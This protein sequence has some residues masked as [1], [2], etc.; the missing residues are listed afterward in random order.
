[1]PWP[2]GQGRWPLGPRTHRRHRLPIKPRDFSDACQ[3]VAASDPR[4]VYQTFTTGLDG[5]PMPSFAD[6]L[7]ED[8]RWQLVWYVMSL[9]HDFDLDRRAP[10]CSA[11]AR[12]QAA[13]SAASR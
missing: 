2:I 6:F 13:V 4:G 8:E 11:Q 1:M 9:R 12:G 3:F 7:K 10:R 5:T